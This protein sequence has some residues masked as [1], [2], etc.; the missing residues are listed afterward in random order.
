MLAD[1][2][3]RRAV[4]AR[5]ADVEQRR[6]ARETE[7][8]AKADAAATEAERARNVRAAAA[9]GIKT[10][11]DVETGK[12]T[13]ATQASGA[14]AW[15]T[16]PV[17][18]P[19]VQPTA[20]AA[21]SSVPGFG[22]FMQLTRP[23]N[24]QTLNQ[25]SEVAQKYRNEQGDTIVQP[26]PSDTDPK[27]GAITGKLKDEFGAPQTVRLGTDQAAVAKAAKDAELEQRRQEILLRSN[28]VEQDKAG[29]TPRWTGPNGAKTEFDA[30]GK[31]LNAFND[32][33]SAPFMRVTNADGTAVWYERDPKTGKPKL[34]Q[35]QLPIKA[36]QDE[37]A[38]WQQNKAGLEARHARAKTAHDKL[39]PKAQNLNRNETEIEAARLKLVN[40]KIRHDSGMPDDDG[41]A[42]TILATASGEAGKPAT[43]QAIDEHVFPMVYAPE[44]LDAAEATQKA[45]RAR[46]PVG[47]A[48]GEDLEYFRQNPGVTG[49]AIGAGLNESPKDA[50]RTVVLNPFAKNPD[51]SPMTDQQKSAVVM[52]ESLRHFMDE[53]KPR[54]AFE[55]TP[56]QVKFFAGTEYGKPENRERLKETIIARILTGDESAGK[57]TPEQEAAAQAVMTQ[58]NAASPDKPLIPQEEPNKTKIFADAFGGL[59]AADQLTLGDAGEGYQ[60]I[61]RKGQPIGRVDKD[62]HGNT[63]VTMGE[64]LNGTEDLRQSVAFGSTKGVHVYLHDKSGATRDTVKEAQY[65]A[66]IFDALKDPILLENKAM[67][68]ARLAML[69]ATPAAIARKVS[70]GEMSI[71]HGEAIMKEVYNATLKADDPLDGQ[72]FG[73]WIS[74]Q[75]QEIKDKYTAAA[76]S[77]DTAA[78]NAIKNDY[79]SEWFVANRGK[80]GVNFKTREI[81]AAALTGKLRTG[82]TVAGVGGEMVQAAGSMLGMLS[83]PVMIN[84]LG[85]RSLVTGDWQAFD[86]TSE[87]YGRASKNTWRGWELS[88]EK[89]FTPE[90]KAKLS[91]LEKAKADLR[92][93][94]VAQ[95][96]Y[97]EGI[98]NPQWKQEYK[99]R[100]D[101]VTDAAFGMHSM[102]LESGWEVTRDD[103]D[104]SKNTALAKLVNGYA[105]TGDKSLLDGYFKALMEDHGSRQAQGYLAD[106]TMGRG[107]FMSGLISGA[108]A[109]PEEIGI[110][111]ASSLLTMGIGA[112]VFGGVKTAKLMQTGAEALTAANRMTKFRLGALG[113]KNEFMTLGMVADT[114]AQPASK[115]GKAS[116]FI[117]KGAKVSAANSITEGL[118]EAAMAPADRNANAQ[119]VAHDAA[120]GALAGFF[121]GPVM[122]A[123][124]ALAQNSL[125]SYDQTQAATKFADSYNT[126]NRGAEGFS[127]VTVEQAKTAMALVPDDVR[128]KLTDASKAAT[129]NLIA[130]VEAAKNST[131]PVVLNALARAQ[132]VSLITH[133]ALATDAAKRT[134]AVLAIQNTDPA[135]KDFAMAL[136]K[137]ASG[138][139]DLLTGVERSAVGG[140]Q[141]QDGKP[142]FATVRK[143]TADGQAVTVD[144]VTDAG[145]AEALQDFPQVAALI[146]TT[147]SQAIFD[148]AQAAKAPPTTTTTN[149]QDPQGTPGQQAPPQNSQS[150]SGDPNAPLP[151]GGSGKPAQVSAGSGTTAGAAQAQVAAPATGPGAAEM[152]AG[153]YESQR[154]GNPD[155]PSI[156]DTVRQAFDAGRPVSVSMAKAANMTWPPTYTQQGNMLVPPAGQP[157]AATGQS[158]PKVA[159]PEPT[160]DPVVETAPVRPTT[161]PEQQAQAKTLA[162]KLKAE[163]EASMPN[164]KGRIKISDDKDQAHGGG[165]HADVDGTIG[166]DIPDV[167]VRIRSVGLKA[168]ET[169]LRIAIIRHEARHVAQIEFVENSRQD[170]ESFSQAWKRI[171]GQDGIHGEL[172]K[173]P[174]LLDRLKEIYDGKP[175]TE[176]GTSAWEQIPTDANKAAEGVRILLEIYSDPAKAKERAEVSEL[177]RAEGMKDSKLASLIES[178]IAKIQELIASLTS[179]DSDLFKPLKEHLEGV[180]ALYADLIAAPKASKEATDTKTNTKAPEAPANQPP[181]EKTPESPA[182]TALFTTGQAITAAFE[183]HPLLKA[184]SKLTEALFD[185]TGE[186][187]D[188]VEAMEPGARRAFL[189]NAFDE[190]IAELEQVKEAKAKEAAA[191]KN[192]ERFARVKAMREAAKSRLRDKA[193]AILNSDVHEALSAIFAKGRITPKP[194]VI[195]LILARQKA[196]AKL[197]EKEMGIIRN[198][199]DFDGMPRK[200]DYPGGGN[201]AVIREMLDML[202]ARQGDGQMPN[203]MADQLLPNLTTASEMF[204]QMDAELRSISRGKKD[205]AGYNPMDDPNYEPSD[206][207]IADWE[208]SQAAALQKQDTQPHATLDD[209]HGYAIETFGADAPI[210]QKIGTIAAHADRFGRDDMP[211]VREGIAAEFARHARGQ[212]VPEWHA[213]NTPLA[214]LAS[215]VVSI[216][217][218]H[219]PESLLASLA[220]LPVVDT[221]SALFSSATPNDQG[222]RSIVEMPP[223][224][225]GHSLDATKHPEYAAAKAGDPN[226]ALRVARD[227]V[228]PQMRA[229]VKD[230][231]GDNKPIIVPVVAMEATGNNMIPHAVAI[232]LEES[233]GLASTAEIVQAVR[234]HRSDKSGLDRVFS[235]PE[236]SGPVKQGETY[237]L[238]DDTLTQGGTFA[239]LADYITSNGGKV[240]GAVALTGK[241][242]SAT[243][244]LSDPLL[245]QLRKR[246]GDLEDTFRMATGH[247][248]DRLT[249]SEARTLVSYGPLERV[250]ARIIEA[251]ITRGDGLDALNEGQ[252]DSSLGSSLQSSPA[253][254]FAF[255][256]TTDA[257]DKSQKGLNFEAPQGKPPG[258]V[259]SNDGGVLGYS[260]DSILRAQQGGSLAGNVRPVDHA[261]AAQ[262][263]M[264]DVDRFKIPVAKETVETY[265]L[266]LPSSYRLDG[267]NYVHSDTPAPASPGRFRPKSMVEF[268][269]PYRGPS[270]ASLVAYEWK[271]ELK[272]TIDKRGE[273]SAVR[274]SN[275]NEAATNWQTGREIVHQ[276]HVTSPTGETRVTSLESAL[277]LLGY[278]SENGKAAGPVRSL[279]STL[280]SRSLLAM[281]AEALRP[282]VEESKATAAR[283]DKQSIA[284]ER[285]RMPKPVFTVE[286]GRPIMR[287]GPLEK[288]GPLAGTPESFDKRSEYD[289]RSLENEWRMEEAKKR[290]GGAGDYRATTKLREIEDR[291]AKLDRK[292]QEQSAAGA[293]TPQEAT[294]AG[295]LFS[296][297]ANLPAGPNAKFI[298]NIQKAYDNATTDKARENI[299]NDSARR[300][301]LKRGK[302]QNVP[303]GMMDFGMSGS[304]GTKDQPGLFSS[305]TNGRFEREKADILKA[306][307]R[308]KDGH[309]LAP[310]GQRSNLTEDQWA[311]VRIGNFKRWFGDWEGMAKREA[312]GKS[313]ETELTG[314]EVADFSTLKPADNLKPYREKA[315][316]WAERN[317]PQ[318]ITNQA[319]GMEIEL[320]RSG[321]ESSLEHGSGPGKI[322][323]IA[324]LPDLLKNGILLDRSGDAGGRPITIHTLGAKLNIGTRS[325]VARMVVRED[326]NGKL[327]YDHELSTIES[328]DALSESGAASQEE[329]GQA[330]ARRGK[331]NVIRSIFSVNPESVSKV[332]DENGEPLVV[333]H[334][335]KEAGFDT[336]DPSMAGS[337]QR[338]DSVFFSDSR[339]TARTYS[340]SL[341]DVNFAKDEDGEPIPHRAIYAVFLNIRN[342]NEA[343]FEGA[344]WDGTRTGQFM[345]IDAEG[346]RLYSDSGRGYFA[347]EEDAQAVADMNDGAEVVP[348]EDGFE[349]TNSV[350]MDA[351]RY[352]NDGAIIY[353]VIDDG[354]EAETYDTST[355]FVAF[356]ANQ[357]KSAVANNG[358]FSS[359]PSILFSS[360]SNQRSFDF[361]VTGGF[362]TRNQ[363]GFDFT[364]AHQVAAA[365]AETDTNPTDAQIEAGN[366]R[367]GK[368]TLHGMPISI[369]NPRGSTRNGTDK[370]G[371]AWSVEMAHHYGY[372]LGTEGKD[373]DHVDTFIGPDVDSTAAFVVNQINPG[374]GRFDEH[375]VMLGFKTRRE[376]LDGYLASY[377]PG[378]KGLGDMVETNVTALKAWIDSGKVETPVNVRTFDS[379]LPQL[380]SFKGITDFREPEAPRTPEIAAIPAKTAENDD[381]DNDWTPPNTQDMAVPLPSY[382]AKSKGSFDL[383]EMAEQIEKAKKPY[384]IQVPVSD[385]PGPSGT[386]YTPEMLVSESLISEEAAS[387]MN[388]QLISGRS[389]GASPRE[390]VES[391]I[392]AN[393]TRNL[394]A[395]S[396]KDN[397]AMWAAYDARQAVVQ[398]ME[399]GAEVLVDTPSTA[400][401]RGVKGT[402][403]RKF[404]KNWRIQT[405]FG[406]RLIRPAALRPAEQ[407]AP[408]TTPEPNTP[409]FRLLPREDK[410]EIVKAKTQAK[411]AEKQGITDF[412]EKLGGARKD[413]SIKT[414]ESARPKKTNDK[415]GWFNRY[416]IGEVVSEMKPASPLESYMARTSGMP[417]GDVGR[418]IITDK[419]KTDYF[420]KP[421]RATR[422]SFATREEAEAF[423]PMIEVS[424]NHRVRSEKVEG[425]GAQMSSAEAS[426]MVEKDA[427]ANKAD[428]EHPGYFS[429]RFVESARTRLDEGS[430]SQEDFDKIEAT[431]G[432]LAATFTPAERAPTPVQPEYRYGIWRIVSDKK[433]VQVVKQTFDSEKEAMEFMAKHAADIIETK[434]SWR[435]ELIVK[436][437]NAVR[438][439]PE[440]RQGPATAEMFQDAFGFRGVEFGNWMRQA[441]DGKE[442]QEVLNHAYDGLLDLAELLGI[443]PKAISLNGELGL[444]FGAR[445]QG[446][447]GAK[448]H[449]EPDYVVINLTKMSGAGSL[450][451]EWI[452]ALD[453]YLGRQD[454]RASSQL[455]KNGD[456]DMVLKPGAF[457]NNAVSSGFSRDSKVRE[458]VRN[459]FVRLMDTL[460]TKAVEYVEDSNNAE[461]FVAASRKALEDHLASMRKDYTRMPDARWEKRRKVATTAQLA[462]F[463]SVADRLINGQDLATDWRTILGGKSR[464]GTVRWTNDTLEQLGELHKAIT[465]R[466][467]FDKERNGTLDNLRGYMTRYAERIKMLESAAAS[468]TKVKK[469]PTDFSMNAKRIDQGSASDYWNVPHEMLARGFSAYVEDRIADT[470]G[471]SDFLSY[472]SDNRLAKYRMFNVKPFPEGAEREA[473]NERFDNLF[474]TIQ[475]EETD[476]GVRL[477]SSPAPDGAEFAAQATAELAKH[478]EIFRY[479]VSSNSSLRSVMADVFPRA[480]FRGDDTRPDESQESGADK[481]TAFSFTADDGKERLFYVYETDDSSPDVWIDVSRLTEG[482]AGS[483]IYA[484]VGN[485][486]HNTGGSFIGDPAGLSEAATVRR[487][488]AM[489]SLALRFGSTSFMEPSK[490]QLEGI[491]EKGIAPLEW[492]G[493]DAAKVRSLIQT[494]LSN[495]HAKYPGI[496]DARYDFGTGEFLGRND[497]P[498]QWGGGWSFDK[499]SRT[500]MGRAARAG[501]ASLRR[502]ILLQSLVS[503]A[504]GERSDVLGQL[505]NRSGSVKDSGLA[506]LFSSPTP[507]PDL[508]TAATAPDAR[509]NLGQVKVGTMHA[510][511]AYR[512]LTAKRNAGKDLTPKEEQQLLDAETALGQKLAFDM[513][514]V[515][516]TAPTV[517]DPLTVQPAARFG[518]NRRDAQ[519]EMSRA[520][521]VDRSGQISLLSS[522][523][524][525]PSAV[526]IALE[527]MPPFFRTVFEMAQAGA[528]PQEIMD[529][530]PQVTS[531]KGVTNILNQTRA[532]VVA[533]TRAAAGTLQPAMS[534]GQFIDG[535]PDLAEGANP[536]FVALDQIRN[537]SDIP[538]TI[539]REENYAEAD[540]RLAADYEGEIARLMEQHKRGEA[541]NKVDIAIAKRAMKRDMFAGGFSDPVKLARMAMLRMT[542]REVGSEQARAFSMRQDEDMSPSERNAMFLAEILLEPPVGTQERLK[543]ADKPTTEAIMKQWRDQI[544]AFNDELKADGID[545]EAALVEFGQHQQEIEQAKAEQQQTAGIIDETIRKLPPIEKAVIESIRSGALLTDIMMTTGLSAELILDIN[546]RFNAKIRES[547]VAA[548]KRFL[549]GALGS[550]PVDMMTQ[551]LAELGVWGNDVIDN[552]QEGFVDRR[553]EILHPRPRKPRPPETPVKPP[554]PP[555]T[556]EQQAAIAAAF[557]R[558]KNADPATWNT[559]FQT[560]AKTLAPLI[561]QVGFEEFKG[562]LLQPWRDRWQTEMDAITNPAGRITF[563]EWIAK[564]ATRETARRERVLFPQPINETTGTFD[565]T[566][567]NREGSLFP[568]PINDT[569]G[570]WN[571]TR[572]YTAQGE[573]IREEVSTTQGT[574]NIHDPVAMHEVA[575]AWEIRNASFTNKLIEHAKMSMLSG[576]QT[577]LV[578]A[579]GALNMVYDLTARR[580]AEAAWNDLLSGFGMG[581]VRSAT[582]SEF[583]PMARQIGAALQLA[584]RNFMRSWKLQSSVFDSYAAG[585]AVQKD[586]SG[587]DLTDIPP[588]NYMSTP[589]NTW[590]NPSLK[591]VW[592]TVHWGLRAITFRELTAVDDFNKGLFS[593]MH[594]AAIAHRIAAKEEKLTG[595]AYAQRTLELMQPGSLAWSRSVAATRR[596]VF[597][598]P[599]RFGKFTAQ[600][601]KANPD[602]KEGKTMSWV[603]AAKKAQ[604]ESLFAFMDVLAAK[605]LELRNV[606]FIGPALHLFALPFVPTVKNIL[607]RG[608]EVMPATSALGMPI[609]FGTVIDILDATRSLRRRMFAGKLTQ[610]E[611]NRIA[612]ELYNKH[613]FLQ[614]LTNQTISMA[615]YFAVA[616]LIGGDDDDEYGRP[617]MTGTAPFTGTKKGDRDNMDHVMPPQSF[618][619]GRTIIPYGR[620]EPFGTLLSGAADMANAI[621][622]NNGVF[623]AQAATDVLTGFKEQFK[624]KL[625]L[626]GI[627]DILRVVENPQRGADRLAASYLTLFVPNVIRQPLRETDEVVRNKNPQADAGFL[628]AVAQRVGYELVPKSAPPKLDVWGDPIPAARGEQFLGS[629]AADTVFRVFD[630]LNV[631]IN[632]KVA[633]IDAW[634][635][636]YNAAQ[637]DSKQ[638]IGIEVIDDEISFTVPGEAR[639]RKV[640]LTPQEHAQAIRNIGQAAKEILG[641]EWDWRTATQ[642]GAVQQAERITDVFTQLKRQ[643]TGRIKREKLAA[644]LPPEK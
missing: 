129:T 604:T 520:G 345:V 220:S 490:S 489:L 116:N 167:A 257:G 205:V 373:K 209:A 260:M 522:P 211:A 182:P 358:Q 161:T 203:V 262:K 246:L 164:L 603:Q 181:A 419:R 528:T 71:Q 308:G 271:H 117:V 476:K 338:P 173:I 61:K 15:K 472:G 386:A 295:D 396:R 473:I 25:T 224:V 429:Y 176:S 384:P 53:N 255:N 184:D 135:N 150:A 572:P 526:Q 81:A 121:M 424:R 548:A 204:E 225:I 533:A 142:Y 44:V 10:Q 213:E 517:K 364:P 231:I 392:R 251:A 397:P 83:A 486:A 414:G 27:T 68:T 235:Q 374:N 42:A 228:T 111:I 230:L 200:I 484:A 435:E 513:E 379:S 274:V 610:E 21:I 269:K 136:A 20:E 242:Y 641:D 37:L 34:D 468:E 287:I 59:V 498:I 175:T 58:F 133:D 82:E 202:Y 206:A 534:D 3:R 214:G 596:A 545:L 290:A 500:G 18:K 65:V 553:K 440:R 291:I 145:R 634:I 152:D 118:E 580:A 564:P 443:P 174:G 433:R 359:D 268:A 632:P 529:A 74:G 540:R 446:L 546:G 574:F 223:A 355:V 488:S 504:G 579:S 286:N 302:V 36:S 265:G 643:E 39:Y 19:F 487:T 134:E 334:G 16:G 57:V 391:W 525:D 221:G 35:Y 85:A 237:L 238:V 348:A 276:F 28:R 383:Y 264:A 482:D 463:D 403:L 346:E 278:T 451:H 270:G 437:D 568:Q 52:N 168:A 333:Y 508:F 518:Q 613:R 402:L 423:I 188:V 452:H 138:R 494:F 282:V 73:T 454:G 339:R 91:T 336:F 311:T 40:E 207:E 99:A 293:E 582:L 549:A 622:R 332:V 190:W 347:D 159:A 8:Q 114:L 541:P 352:G 559:L 100:I 180:E 576:P 395:K 165:V 178:V 156:A 90:G 124:A 93:T 198:V 413:T 602:H 497:L 501:Q 554:A 410:A 327:F 557:E 340:G 275:W 481:R 146:Q 583:L 66:S 363:P 337:R 56:E 321:V 196:G 569:T 441:G 17:G 368:V 405:E 193:R 106:L 256:Q 158:E 477:F 570:T 493:N 587:F 60:F 589:R 33:K 390:L 197:T 45:N 31:A 630:P 578:N 131:D 563:D 614:T 573:L 566:A 409:D 527:A 272:E 187:A 14:P 609:A 195:G 132:A 80:P 623:N 233:L 362:N 210:T 30:A 240:V 153:M 22:G 510:L 201:N 539:S 258:I 103:L 108:N 453:H 599:I 547:M 172:A 635:Y 600:D 585:V 341:N 169:E 273:D 586:F 212:S 491:P 375:K 119:T 598:D 96:A 483:G 267:E 115:L 382:F 618:R 186:L 289:L 432:A 49:M 393:Q 6:V 299:A 420:G 234:A 511:N 328:L 13:I 595:A 421:E 266:N 77:K 577:A 128:V 304:F 309:P 523:A 606:P 380:S 624:D 354:G 183:R 104:P 637:P 7:Q 47:N 137:V 148:A 76:S 565:T 353:E 426:A 322:Q 284:L 544:R 123:P 236:F 189:D 323:S 250:R 245:V 638:R 428:R 639:P 199:S 631:R 535:R 69:D 427:A 285:E 92:S 514:A 611:S 430:L 629:A 229:S 324:A 5:Q 70:T 640:A 365:A 54:L 462:L 401:P 143:F 305:P 447:S 474:A 259:S 617:H 163:L 140:K 555:L 378:W 495:L 597:Q 303:Q 626:K 425:T 122:A 496:R 109:P 584:G 436:P 227:L 467:G 466:T 87:N 139:T 320:R 89:W 503:S 160:A 102:N 38:Y 315:K 457:D 98:E 343:H 521:E 448:A 538:A 360:P 330:G 612:H 292:I 144:V 642:D 588:A 101:A 406:E 469:V 216:L 377:T 408:N 247:G 107:K 171:Y 318:T 288:W 442:R 450:A 465:N 149:E 628:K 560:E 110:E 325:Y 633:A 177:L 249:E 621:R 127:P 239:A 120:I 516:G 313:R 191:K 505:L 72:T 399:P 141:T 388:G 281:E 369:E 550:S 63:F 1:E 361:G 644:G 254:E 307:P 502:G 329:V 389:R 400:F 112:A 411:T 294:T 67:G 208:A 562:K 312:L 296:T 415:P 601:Q 542:Y 431:H 590:E 591:N 479:R 561:G 78:L 620:I 492:K 349:T 11:T 558:F 179:Q 12:T 575:A 357:V 331:P 342:P 306:A 581:D 422:Q 105:I 298:E 125:T 537:E 283:Y 243:L 376:A 371:K 625:F 24:Q 75:D 55:P 506:G 297:I 215:K 507:Q 29:F 366:Y 370:N 314:N 46:Y 48:V 464:Y 616:S 461:K 605:A 458:E 130:A 43:Q 232:R 217:R 608:L 499:A 543:T 449:Y 531:E 62:K 571:D 344:N 607:Q 444:A 79:A 412:G 26:L 627:G 64:N 335:S 316:A 398:A 593:Q 300:E 94:I 9:Q 317:L 471:T 619:L 407:A 4:E 126:A 372:F 418:F 277:K 147:E 301:G 515:K 356:D 509:E 218:N 381:Q 219:T 248:F 417:T 478:D 280:R 32:P 552:R 2:G 480:Q 439:G 460:M 279:A 166:L 86:A 385:E 455:V 592:G 416:E 50:P 226:A 261:K 84:Y 445:G 194:N 387:N 310:N 594:T 51:G 185:L 253:P 155:L 154:A 475:S 88:R 23:A 95:D 170:G 252:G 636:R 244:R 536:D 326:Q 530:V 519:D 241:Q 404:P 350:A 434:T 615:V 551:I 192:A 459:A 151:N 567:P 485:Y 556:P 512:A 113:L 532:R 456:G 438:K 162:E 97:P 367:K 470:G 157:A 394:M 222:R 351:S 41:G 524:P 319:S 263:I